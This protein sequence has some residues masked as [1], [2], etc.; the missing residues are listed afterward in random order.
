[1][2]CS[3]CLE[4]VSEDKKIL[5]CGHEFHTVCIDLWFNEKKE[6][7]VCRTSLETQHENLVQ[8]I[9]DENFETVRVQSL[10]NAE[11]L[12]FITSFMSFSLSFMT[13]KENEVFYIFFIQSFICMAYTC[14]KINVQLI[15]ILG[16]YILFSFILDFSAHKFYNKNKTNYILMFSIFVFQHIFV[17]IVEKDRRLENN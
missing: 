2:E 17:N 9:E 5:K 16:L 13:R 1:M 7:P 6:C 8:P 15:K 4:N 14:R 3:I 10:T 11:G 12:L